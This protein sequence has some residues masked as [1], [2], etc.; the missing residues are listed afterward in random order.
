MATD[1]FSAES[2][3]SGTGEPL[4][5]TPIHW[6]TA[7]LGT[8]PPSPTRPPAWPRAADVDTAD[9]PQDQALHPTPDIDLDTGV[10]WEEAA[11]LAPSQEPTSAPLLDAPPD[12]DGEAVE[13][14]IRIA[15]LS[16]PLDDIADLVT[17]LE[18][19][20]DGAPTAASVLRLA[21]VARSVDDVTRLVEL[22]GPPQHPADH[23]DEAI[24]HAAQE[25]PVPD[26]THLVRLLSRS[27]HDPHSSAEAVHAAATSR[28][29]ED[30]IQL[31]G[32]LGE[33]SG[34]G[35][36]VVSSTPAAPPAETAEHAETAEPE[37]AAEASHPQKNRNSSRPQMWLRRT[38]GVL[39]LLCAAAHFPMDWSQS[40]AVSVS[41]AIGVSAICAA[42]GIALCLSRS[43]AVA[44]AAALL[45]GAL[46][47]GHLMDD[48]LASGSLAR[49]LQP[50]GVPAPLPALSAVIAA[51]AALLVV[52]ITVAGL[53]T[54]AADRRP[55]PHV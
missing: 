41:A 43:T 7:Q 38:A 24:R 21:A 31:I 5:S 4:V 16:R 26:V 19:T 13:E 46:A 50:E 39:M 51:L 30:L 37:T 12:A 2:E 44:V 49:V 54:P 33:H 40:S 47:V 17:R 3:A 35:A 34:N 8:P 48:R 1:S 27:P 29:V 25:R 52:A 28:S 11:A 6:G 9:A 45:A 23:M 36:P 20:P 14:L 55:E 42:A 18:Q 53:R 22:L 15:V 32:S 10:T